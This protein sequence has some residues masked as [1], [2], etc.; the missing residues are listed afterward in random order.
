MILISIFVEGITD[1]ELYKTFFIKCYGFKLLDSEEEDKFRKGLTRKGID[2]EKSEFPFPT[3]RVRLLK[4][5]KQ[6]VYI[7]I[8]AKGGKVELQKFAFQILDN[9]DKVYKSKLIN[10][11]K[12]SVNVKSFFV[13]DEGISPE[14]VNPDEKYLIVIKQQYLPE[15][16]I[17]DFLEK[18]K[19]LKHIK[20]NFEKLM[21]LWKHL[22][23][24]SQNDKTRKKR[25]VNLLKSLF[26][27]R[28]HSHLFEKLIEK[29]GC[30]EM[31]KL[32]PEEIT[33]VCSV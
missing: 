24:H 6:D 15:D 14:I 26:G 1:V 3:R 19:E 11:N 22:Q 30:D 5:K 10:F 29:C 16:V 13:F 4:N 12:V 31:R 20:D 32:L 17:L 23:L 2:V 7:S 8:Q 28:C 33:K 27:E 9:W 18:C 25:L 21:E